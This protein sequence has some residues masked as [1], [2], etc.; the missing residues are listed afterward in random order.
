[1]NTTIFKNPL[2]LEKAMQLSKE[3]PALPFNSTPL[4]SKGPENNPVTSFEPVKAFDNVYWIGSQAVGAVIINTGDGYVMIDDG[5][6]DAEAEHM[7]KSLEKLNINGNE[8]KLI[9]ISHE[10]FDHYGG[11]SYFLKNV[12]PNAKIAISRIGWNLLQTVPTE[13]AFTDPRPEKADILIF[14]GM[15]LELGN[16]KI[17]CV[18]TPGHSDGCVS[19]IFNA[20]YKN[21]E[22]MVGMMGG[23]AVWPNMPQ[24]RMYQSSIEYFKLYTDMAECDAFISAHRRKDLL[25]KVNDSW[26]GT[27]RNPWVCGKENYDEEYLTPFRNNALRTV[28]SD[29]TQIYMM[30]VSP[31]TGE[32]KAEGSPIP[33]KI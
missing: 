21:E 22:I 19:F 31:V 24:I 6:S 12:C 17:L 27:C 2:T 4:F 10:H 3:L 32:A 26:N 14:D 25:D 13:F 29:S 1:M 8:I 15:C 7:A 5:S 30:P 28:K 11:T 9:I 20:I 23:S 16:T 18:L 33:E